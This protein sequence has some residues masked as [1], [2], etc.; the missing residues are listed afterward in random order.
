MAARPSFRDEVGQLVYPHVDPTRSA[1]ES[2]DGDHVTVRCTFT[3]PQARGDFRRAGLWRFL[4]RRVEGALT[5]MQWYEDHSSGV[6][7]VNL[8]KKDDHLSKSTTHRD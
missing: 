5:G 4:E 6:F 1:L 3:R 2:L 7:L 8:H